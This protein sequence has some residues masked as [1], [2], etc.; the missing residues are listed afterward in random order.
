MIDGLWT[1]CRLDVRWLFQAAESRVWLGS[2][3]GVAGVFCVSADQQCR[4]PSHW[5]TSRSFWCAPGHRAVS[6]A[7][8]FRPHLLFFALG[9]PWALV[10]HLSD[11]RHC[12]GGTAPTGLNLSIAP[13][14]GL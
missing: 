7:F 5:P 2:G 1:A 12:W 10:R 6:G 3:A 13:T 11:P 14:D 8:R 4:F 9:A